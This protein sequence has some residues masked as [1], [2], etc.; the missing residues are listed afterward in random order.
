M[1]ELLLTQ[2]AEVSYND[3][4]VPRF[5]VGRDVFYRDEVVLESVDLTE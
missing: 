5:K 4:Y 1:I 2:G 3:P